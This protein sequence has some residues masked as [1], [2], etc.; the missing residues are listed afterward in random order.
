MSFCLVGQF[1]GY[2]LKSHKIHAIH[3]S[4]SQQDYRL[5]LSS[6]ARDDL[7]RAALE[8]N[9]QVGD[10]VEVSG[11]QDSDRPKGPKLKAHAL[12]RVSPEE[13]EHRASLQCGSQCGSQCASSS[14]QSDHQ[15]GRSSQRPTKVLVCQK[16]SC[17]QRGGKAVLKRI[18]QVVRDRQLEEQVT[19]R[20]TG[21]MGNCGKGPLVVIGKTRCRGVT[22]KTVESL[23]EQHLP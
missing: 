11:L 3:F 16:S 8:G 14:R 21:C 4:H 23:L 9:L 2:E 12:R 5:K 1:L 15:S 7:L 17:C 22:P 18:Q 20:S 10:W 19:L 13:A 6:S